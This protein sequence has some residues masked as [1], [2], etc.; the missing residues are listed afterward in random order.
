MNYNIIL[1]IKDEKEKQVAEKYVQ[2]K[3]IYVKVKSMRK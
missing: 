2:S 3:T 1:E